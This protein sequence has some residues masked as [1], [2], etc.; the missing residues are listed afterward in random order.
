MSR[1]RPDGV[2]LRWMLTPWEPPH[3]FLIDWGPTPHPTATAAPGLRL[4]SLQVPEWPTAVTADPR[5]RR[6]AHLSAT[7]AGPSGVFTL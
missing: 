5:L 3:P 2:V 7:V 1:T 6:G 4:V